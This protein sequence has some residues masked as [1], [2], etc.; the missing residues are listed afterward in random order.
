MERPRRLNGSVFPF[1]SVP[2]QISLPLGVPVHGGRL[3]ERVQD[4]VGVSLHKAVLKVILLRVVI[5][6]LDVGDT[7]FEH[8]LRSEGLRRGVQPWGLSCVASR[9]LVLS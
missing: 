7:L 5:A 9:V 1:L 3:F 2:A 4:P 6:A 8:H